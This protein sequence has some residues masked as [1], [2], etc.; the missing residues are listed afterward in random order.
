[1]CV[2]L[3]RKISGNDTVLCKEAVEEIEEYNGGVVVETTN[4]VYQS[5]AF[6]F[7]TDP[8][9]NFQLQLRRDG[10]TPVAS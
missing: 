2:R 10:H 9:V 6:V 3:H 4:N 5:V 8:N 1:M 7:K